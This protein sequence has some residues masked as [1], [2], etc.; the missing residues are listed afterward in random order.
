M[1]LAIGCRPGS[2]A[3]SSSYANTD[4]YLKWRDIQFFRRED[5]KPGLYLVINVRRIRGQRDA[6]HQRSPDFVPARFLLRPCRSTTNLPLD[7]TWMLPSLA[8]ERG[9]FGNRTLR[10]LERSDEVELGQDPL[11]RDEPVFLKST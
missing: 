9:L 1:S 7:L 5:G 6:F 3:V 8:I 4:Q 10:D 2:L 11:I